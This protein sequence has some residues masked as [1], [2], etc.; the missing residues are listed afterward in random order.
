M[1]DPRTA[2]LKYGHEDFSSCVFPD[3]WITAMKIVRHMFFGPI[4]GDTGTELILRSD[5]N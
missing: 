1:A 2:A 4:V 3:P 5:G